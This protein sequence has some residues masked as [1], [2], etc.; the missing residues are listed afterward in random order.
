[1]YTYM[2][3]LKKEFL[4]QAIAANALKFGNFTLKSGR[5]SPYFFNMGELYSSKSLT[6]IGKI[7]AA[8][9]ARAGLSPD[10]IYGP[11]YKGISI[12]V[13]T[14]ISLGEHNIN[15]GYAFHRKEAKGHGEGGS[16]VG[17]K[18]SGDIVIV[19]DVITK[20]TALRQSVSEIRKS[21]EA[22]ITGIVIALDRKERMDG[23]I[24]A[25][26]QL[27]EDEDIPIYP[28]LTI[29]DIMMLSQEA[30]DSNIFEAIT[31]YQREFCVD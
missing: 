13:A 21:K 10:V 19:D 26:R 27:Q 24:S 7:Y 4:N 6:M 18:L 8:T 14:A 17:A 15:A 22:R 28:V 30:V 20:G 23:D 12:S 16:L 9:I 3:E 25:V 2:D 31:T 1:M 5:K 11:A 29:K